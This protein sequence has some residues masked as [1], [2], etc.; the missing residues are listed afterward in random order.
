MLIAAI[1]SPH[2]HVHFT[3][4]ARAQQL[5][6]GSAIG[7]DFEKTHAAENPE[8]FTGR[9]FGIVR[10]DARRRRLGSNRDLERGRIEAEKLGRILWRDV[11][12]EI[13]KAI[14]FQHYSAQG[15]FIHRLGTGRAKADVVG[16]L[17]AE[18]IGL[19][20]LGE[21]SRYWR[22]NISSME[23]VAARLQKIMF[24]G[25]SIQRLTFGQPQPAR[26]PT[27]LAYENLTPL[28]RQPL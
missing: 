3:S 4:L 25:V 12:D 22:K 19:H 24:G 27:L 11:G 18:A 23:S 1:A 9:A 28:Q 14:D 20:S 8:D 26:R 16:D 7:S 13:A 10:A 15:F 2:H 21:I 5:K 17:F 6:S